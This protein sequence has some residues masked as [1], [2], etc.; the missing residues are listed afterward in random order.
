[1]RRVYPA[2]TRITSSNMNPLKFWRTGAQVVSLNWQ[3]YDTGMQIN[4]AMFVGSGGW[5]VK[6]SKLRLRNN[7]GGGKK[8]V[9]FRMRSCGIK[10]RKGS[11]MMKSIEAQG[12]G[13][14]MLR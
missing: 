10:R 6:P 1:M 7:G 2:G 4:D 12:R 8:K 3:N 5:V 13:N 9:Y 11:R 14:R